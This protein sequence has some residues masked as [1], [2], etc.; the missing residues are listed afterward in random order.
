MNELTTQEILLIVEQVLYSTNHRMQSVA[1]IG[2]SASGKTYIC[3]LIEQRFSGQILLFPVDHYYKGRKY[4]GRDDGS[5]IEEVPGI[6]VMDTSR[7]ENFD[8][9]RS[10]DLPLAALHIGEFLEYGRTATPVYDMPRSCRSSQVR[11]VERSGEKILLYDGLFLPE[12]FQPDYL[13]F[14]DASP[15]SRLI[16]R[17][18]RDPIRKQIRPENYNEFM[19]FTLFYML[20]TVFPM[21][22]EYIE[23]V[24]K[25]A[26]F[27]VKNE[28]DPNLERESSLEDAFSLKE[29]MAYYEIPD[30]IKETLC[31]LRVRNDYW[32]QYCLVNSVSL[33][34]KLCLNNKQ[35]L[36]IL[37]QGLR[38]CGYKRKV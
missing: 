23:P 7:A 10:I 30:R 19:T 9:P 12:G 4:V 8:E 21:H 22:R 6:P 29:E 35:T 5:F 3:H 33:V 15:H 36:I 26:K 32:F 31:I 27:V 17:L 1:I 24:K 13:F 11:L 34:F 18:M 20:G 38:A 25:M 2:G 28:Y 37:D 14:V 16:R